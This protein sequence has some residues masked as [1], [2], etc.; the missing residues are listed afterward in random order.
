MANL[1]ISVN[2][3][4]KKE[5]GEFCD[6]VG[7]SSSSLLNMFIKTVIREGRI[8]F[9]ISVNK[10][11]KPNRRTIRAMKEGDDLLVAEDALLSDSK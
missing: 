3:S 10:S 7:I 2:D 9:E 1:T 11:E 5:F 4:D 6:Q 8:P